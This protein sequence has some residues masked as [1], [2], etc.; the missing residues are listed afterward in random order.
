VAEA[1]A[2]VVVCAYT[3]RRWCDIA[4]AIE[5]VHSQSRSASE[6][7]LVIDHNADLLN[8]A[9]SA[10]PS[11]IVIENLESQGLSGARNTGVAKSSG[12]VVVFLDDDALPDRDWLESMLDPY[13][14]ERTLGVGG[15]VEPWWQGECPT[16]FPEE[17]G[18]V[19]GCS[20]RG[21]PTTRAQIRNPIGANMSFRR[22]VLSELGGFDSRVGRI[23][24]EPT[25][26]EETELSIRAHQRF[27]DGFVIFEPA[28]RVRHRVTPERARFA[29]FMSRCWAEGRSKAVVSALLGSDA[30]LSSERSYL[31]RVLPAGIVRTLVT[32]VRTGHV[33]EALRG[34]A[35]VA[36]AVA[37]VA[38]YVTEAA[39]QQVVRRRSLIS[40]GSR[41]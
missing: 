20:Y 30:A 21:Q 14:D 34:G 10:F 18:W 29:Y 23:G 36:G 1:T 2:T 6:T 37:T 41:M 12:D 16:W 8:R 28:A 13:T 5:A 31:T 9:R 11:V 38:G 22:N 3:A 24:T 17:F 15:F 26:C 19:V 40:A 33:A 4:L 32:A 35:I 25:G 39:R 27:P 7:I